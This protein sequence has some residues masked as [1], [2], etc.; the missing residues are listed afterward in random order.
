[1]RTPRRLAAEIDGAHREGRLLSTGDFSEL[2]DASAARETARQLDRLRDPD[3]LRHLSDAL[4]TH[5]G[6]AARIV[7]DL[8]ESATEPA[9]V[10]KATVRED[11][12]RELL[13]REPVLRRA[14]EELDLELMD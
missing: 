2:G 9:R 11:R 4:T 1:M 7:V 10:T 3:T 14:V 8:E 5:L 13:Q 6:H 12:L